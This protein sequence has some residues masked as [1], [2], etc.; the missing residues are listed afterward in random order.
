MEEGAQV[1]NRETE[2]MEPLVAYS[3]LEGL[4]E[5]YFFFKPLR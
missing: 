4:S 1:E 3:N 2:K 5:I